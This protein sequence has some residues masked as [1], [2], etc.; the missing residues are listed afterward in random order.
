M[1]T[2]AS[3]LTRSGELYGIDR[4]HLQVGRFHDDVSEGYIPT[5]AVEEILMDGLANFLIVADRHLNL[6]PPYEVVAG[7]EGIKGFTLAVNPQYFGYEKFVGHI[8]FNT[9]GKTA[10]VDDP[11]CDSFD[12]LLPL[13]KEIYDVAGYERPDVRTEGK[14]QR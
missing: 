8:F 13:F 6:P 11:N 7:V 9:V 12:V 14:F 10:T 3:L 1:A 2:T 4:Y 5:G